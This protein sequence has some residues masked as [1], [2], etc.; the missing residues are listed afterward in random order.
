MRQLLVLFAL[1]LF[2]QAAHAQIGLGKKW[3]KQQQ[4]TQIDYSNPKT[5][6]IEA[7]TVK[8]ANT[9]NKNALISLSGLKTGDKIKV[10][11][12][13]ISNAIRKLWKQGIIADVSIK[14]EKT[15]GDKIWLIIDLTERP[16]LSII[17][18]YGAN[19]TQTKELKEEIDI[20]KGKVLT[21][22][23]Q[24]NTEIIASKYFIKKGFLN[25][26]VKIYSEKDMLLANHVKMIVD[27]DKGKK[28]HIDRINFD[29][30]KDLDETKLKSKM[31]KTN[32]KVRVT[33]FKDLTSRILHTDAQKAK[34]FFSESYT[35]TWKDFKMYL[36][37]HIKLNFFSSSKFIGSEFEEDKKKL[38]AYY[39]SKGYRDA[40][41]LRDSVYVNEGGDVNIDIEVFEGKKYYF[42]D[43]KWVGN[44][45][46]TDETLDK[47]LGIKTGDVYDMENL[48]KRLTFDPTKQDV[49]SI[50]M[51][52]GYLASSI[53]P[54]EV[55]VEGDSIDIEMR[56]HEGKQF[57]IGNVAISGNDRTNDHV[58]I[59]E[60]YTVPGDLFNRSLLIR[61]QKE[62]SQLGYFD[63]EQTTPNVVPNMANE[64][65]DITW[66]L[67]ERPSDQI[68]L[69]GGWG[70]SYGFIGTLGLSFNNFSFRNIFNKKAYRPLP[71]GDGQKLSLRAQANGKQYQSYSISFQEP[72]LGGKKRQ[73]FST[74]FSYSSQKQYNYLTRE[75]GDGFLRM[76]GV[77]VGLGRR[78]KWPDDYFSLSNSITF[79]RYDI[80]KYDYGLGFTEGYANN[81][82]FNTTLSRN[83]AEPIYPR[84]G[85]SYTLSA[86]LTPPY[87]LWTGLNYKNRDL[88]GEDRY[89][90]IEYYKIMFDAKNY[91]K[92]VGNLVV[93][94]KVHFGFLG[95]YSEK[96]GVG[97]F[98]RFVMGGS[99]LA[100]QNY[101]LGTE[102]VSL[103]GYE[104]RA[105]TP[106]N[107][108]ISGDIDG[109]TAYCKFSAEL[110][111]PVSLA[112]A[113]TIY[114]LAFAE[115]GD[116]WGT[117][118]NVNPFSLKKSAGFGA[119]IFMPAF[120][121]IGIDW[122]YGFD[123]PKPG[124][125]KGGSQI[126][127]TIGQ[128]LR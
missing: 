122:G 73:S 76:F 77:T 48:N 99:G 109:G 95:A 117:F 60:L 61:T 89:K 9:L 18:I 6:T 23:I 88:P 10:P 19:K 41:I 78:L 100:G 12:D 5:Y 43:I 16:R 39:N 56:V 2:S 85:S 32:E 118:S 27:I 114:V 120:G 112:Q 20:A 44:F 106:N 46:Y 70:G 40:R 66:E 98:E 74:S 54:V 101:I 50:Y 119:R 67:V 113:A 22:A 115:A 30:V 72:W 97:P 90:W 124:Q 35:S 87:H 128:Q 104:D 14:V 13:K 107:Q 53:T 57:R 42:R 15:E 4:N 126:H 47:V 82:S 125:S 83:S 102:V 49:T 55:R 11:G 58:I 92:I 103:R 68:E 123:S 7:I 110:R 127:F 28:V 64:T 51:D 86:T 75:Y 1:V 38:I 52:N 33:I 17:E 71:T 21:S 31:K 34:E 65:V 84:N 45:I 111:Y 69:S 26:K 36:N 91:M 79:N 37:K 29:G 63:P 121:L 105:I 108:G 25:T 80:N 59:R 62:L 8:G 81:I 24:K 94:S 96:V 3:K 93:E 116:N